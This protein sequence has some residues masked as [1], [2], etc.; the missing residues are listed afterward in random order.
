MFKV[1][2]IGSKGQ[3]PFIFPKDN[4]GKILI[5]WANIMVMSSMQ[6]APIRTRIRRLGRNWDE[7]VPELARERCEEPFGGGA[8]RK[9][10][11]EHRRRRAPAVV[12]G[13]A[14]RTHSLAQIE[15]NKRYGEVRRLTTSAEDASAKQGEVKQR[16]KRPRT[17]AAGVVEDYEIRRLPASTARGTP[18]G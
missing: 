13:G 9:W 14:R 4:P 16:R 1:L 10:S 15:A 17:P 11:P 12:R 8:A 2:T 18:P 7:W 5:G 6:A 3:F